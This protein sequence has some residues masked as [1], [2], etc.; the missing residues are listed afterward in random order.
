VQ[1]GLKVEVLFDPLLQQATRMVARTLNACGFRLANAKLLDTEPQSGEDHG[2]I[3]HRRHPV[4][5]N[6]LVDS[7][8]ITF[9]GNGEWLGRKHGTHR[10]RQYRPVNRQANQ[11]QGM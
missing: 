11:S 6:L 9:L 4:A 2:S 1:C 3:T 8:G 5:W 10:C 7:S